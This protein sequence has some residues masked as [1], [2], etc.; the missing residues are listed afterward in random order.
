[1][2]RLA[3]WN[4]QSMRHMMSSLFW[5]FKQFYLK[6]LS[7]II[8]IL[9]LILPCKYGLRTASVDTITKNDY[10]KIVT[11]RVCYIVEEMSRVWER[12]FG[13]FKGSSSKRIHAFKF[14]TVPV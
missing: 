3:K 12:H 10:L 4:G 6:K 8:T 9:R 13:F 7:I 11:D 1:M 14:L 2:K 5:H